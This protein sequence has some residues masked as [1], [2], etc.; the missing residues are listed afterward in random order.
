M[1]TNTIRNIH[2][3]YVLQSYQSKKEDKYISLHRKKWYITV[4]KCVKVCKSV[5]I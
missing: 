1:N 4:K 2:T 5:Y 3:I